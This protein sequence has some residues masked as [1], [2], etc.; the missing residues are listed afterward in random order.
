RRSSK[1]KNSTRARGSIIFPSRRF[2]N[3]RASPAHGLAILAMVG[4]G[5]VIA[6][7][8]GL[9]WVGSGGDEN[10]LIAADLAAVD[11]SHIVPHGAELFA[12]QAIELRF[13][14]KSV[15][16]LSMA[17]AR[18]VRRRLQVRAELQHVHEHLAM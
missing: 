11:R 16:D 13:Q 2:R 4:T 12:D 15:G 1:S 17:E 8:I 10:R 3:A 9:G 6:A 7:D 5:T 14:P 18:H